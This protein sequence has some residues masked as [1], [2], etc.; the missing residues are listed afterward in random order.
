MTNAIK[1]FTAWLLALIMALQM[2][3]LGV[4]ADDTVQTEPGII[5]DTSTP[6]V[7]VSQSIQAPGL[8]NLLMQLR[9]AGS[10]TI[11][12]IAG[13][14]GS[15][16]TATEEVV[17]QTVH[18]STATPDDSHAFLNWTDASGAVVSTSQ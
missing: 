7:D 14:G 12:Y 13:E 11:N 5:V 4:L 3:P 15:V 18:G 1:K 6:V 10:V 17:D 2:C 8:A 9:A 16:T